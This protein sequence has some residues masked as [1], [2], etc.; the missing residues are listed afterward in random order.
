MFY[1]MFTKILLDN[2]CT[3]DITVNRKIIKMQVNAS[4]QIQSLQAD[5][6]TRNCKKYFDFILNVHHNV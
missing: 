4:S 5:V 3:L 6:K 1:C 2:V